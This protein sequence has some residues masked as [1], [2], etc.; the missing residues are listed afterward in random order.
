MNLLL[1]HVLYIPP[2]VADLV[3]ELSQTHKAKPDL[4]NLVFGTVFSDHMLTIEW[5]NAGGWQK[6]HIK[7]FGNLSLHP[8]CSAMHYAVQVGNAT[9][10]GLVRKLMYLTLMLSILAAHLIVL[11]TTVEIC[12]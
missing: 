8:A 11:K 9:L 7:P 2:Q 5:T 10:L 3:I 6:P 12:W 4:T 1:N